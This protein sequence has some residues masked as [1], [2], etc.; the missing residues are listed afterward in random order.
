[1][2]L[3]V[4]ARIHLAAPVLDRG[5]RVVAATVVAT[6]AAGGTE[7]DAGAGFAV[8]GALLPL[9]PVRSAWTATG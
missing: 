3:A 1:M 8:A 4:P 6:V 2:G 9:V 7:V 5:I